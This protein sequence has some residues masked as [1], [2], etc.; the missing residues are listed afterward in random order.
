MVHESDVGRAAQLVVAAR[1]DDEDNVEVATRESAPTRTG[2][3]ESHVPWPCAFKA[4]EARL[5][6]PNKK[7]AQ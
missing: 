3:R 6:E 4:T 7:T 1:V 2:G 5:A